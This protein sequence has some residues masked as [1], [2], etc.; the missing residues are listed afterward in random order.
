MLITYKV[1]YKIILRFKRNNFAHYS[2]Y[3]TFNGLFGLSSCLVLEFWVI[4][5]VYTGGFELIYSE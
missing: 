5:N 1:E 3:S 4:V 2:I